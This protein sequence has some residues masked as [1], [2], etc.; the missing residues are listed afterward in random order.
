MLLAWALRDPSGSRLLGG[1]S[2]AGH[3][4]FLRPGAGGAVAW[5]VGRGGGGHLEADGHR[6]CPSLCGSANRL[7]DDGDAAF[8]R[9]ASMPTSECR[10]A[11]ARGKCLGSPQ[12][13]SDQTRLKGTASARVDDSDSTR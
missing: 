3:P 11:G 1:A 4:S 12:G 5:V 9:A 7:P 6:Y 10:G 2:P 8:S 13:S